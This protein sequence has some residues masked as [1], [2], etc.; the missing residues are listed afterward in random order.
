MKLQMIDTPSYKEGMKLR[1]K[2]GI[3]AM[4]CKVGL[5]EYQLICL[6]TGNRWTDNGRVVIEEYD[7]AGNH[8]ERFH[9]SDNSPFWGSGGRK[10]W[11]LIEEDKH[12][13][14]GE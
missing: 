9:L 4:I 13:N 7:R 10:E 8:R 1:N 11:E 12:V 5:W 3:E 14:I 6:S 2:F